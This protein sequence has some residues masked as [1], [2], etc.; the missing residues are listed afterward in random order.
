[1]R[2]RAPVY[3]SGSKWEV[4]QIKKIRVEEHTNLPKGWAR[5]IVGNV[6]VCVCVGYLT[7]DLNKGLG[8]NEN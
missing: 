2:K 6:C 8:R 3:L 5:K 7:N 1:M 4:F